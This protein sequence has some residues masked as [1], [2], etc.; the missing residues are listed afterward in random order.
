MLSLTE[1][2]GWSYHIH[3]IAGHVAIDVEER[4]EACWSGQG[5]EEEGK[6][7]TK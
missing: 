4:F 5:K 3:S 6:D 7:E 2:Y 1:F